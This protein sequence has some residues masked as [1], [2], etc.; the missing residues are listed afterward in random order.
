MVGAP[1]LE[2]RTNKKLGIFNGDTYKI[3]SFLKEENRDI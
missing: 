2:I 1:V 3:P